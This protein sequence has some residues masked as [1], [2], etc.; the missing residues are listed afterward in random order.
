MDTADYETTINSVVAQSSSTSMPAKPRAKK[1]PKSRVESESEAVDNVIKKKKT[2]AQTSYPADEFEFE[3]DN[4]DL[5]LV[6]GQENS[7][8]GS[9]EYRVKLY[10]R[11]LL[12]DIGI[13]KTEFITWS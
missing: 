5:D 7:I 4:V 6:T 10:E 11:M 12:F 3:E 13:L 2:N 1:A 9:G 8:N